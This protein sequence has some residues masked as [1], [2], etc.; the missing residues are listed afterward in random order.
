M[1]KFKVHKQNQL[2]GY[3]LLLHEAYIDVKFVAVS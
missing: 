2:C 3:W 1:H